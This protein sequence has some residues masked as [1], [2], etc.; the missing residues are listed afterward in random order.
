[1]PVGQCHSPS[2]HSCMNQKSI[3][4]YSKYSMAAT[5]NVYVWAHHIP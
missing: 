5:Y 4:S 3:M 1:M 2:S